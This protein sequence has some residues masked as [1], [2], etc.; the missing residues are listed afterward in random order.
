MLRQNE[1]EEVKASVEFAEQGGIE[2][3][4]GEVEQKWRRR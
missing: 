2:L 4:V 3:K 1:Q